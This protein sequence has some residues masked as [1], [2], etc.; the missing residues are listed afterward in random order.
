MRAHIQ[1][2]TTE[3]VLCLPPQCSRQ[4]RAGRQGAL[5]FDEHFQPPTGHCLR[6]LNPSLAPSGEVGVLFPSQHF[7]S[8]Y[9]V[10]G[11]SPFPPLPQVTQHELAHPGN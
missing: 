3:N 10:Q 7:L 4:R 5:R 2:H 8:T 6:S 11:W 9:C 1:R